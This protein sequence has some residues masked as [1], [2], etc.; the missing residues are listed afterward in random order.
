[1]ITKHDIIQMTKHIT[2]RSSGK[3]DRRIIHPQREWFIG[4]VIIFVLFIGG[5]MY[6]GYLF[7]TEFNY[8]VDPAT[9]EVKTTTYQNER[10]RD[11]LNAYRE[12]KTSFEKLR[13]TAA[14]TSTDNS[15]VAEREPQETIPEGVPEIP[16]EG[17]ATSTD[18]R[19]E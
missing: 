1:M 12:K 7:F 2:R 18:I 13:G 10:V 4:L 17:L 16:E 11:V 5:S 14:P 19:V 3:R 9:V 8:E 15:G 6:T